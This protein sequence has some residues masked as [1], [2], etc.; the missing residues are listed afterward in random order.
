MKTVETEVWD[1]GTA[2]PHYEYVCCWPEPR[3]H[4][5]QIASVTPSESVWICTGCQRIVHRM[6]KE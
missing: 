1:E 2:P 6:V 5:W 3:T 4:K